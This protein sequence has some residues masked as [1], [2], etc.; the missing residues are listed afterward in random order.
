MNYSKNPKSLYNF[1]KNTVKTFTKKYSFQVETPCSPTVFLVRHLNIYGVITIEKSST[2]PF[3]IFAL[4]FLFDK[5][6]CFEHLYSYTFQKRFNFPKPLA[7]LSAKSCSFYLPKL[8]R[9][10]NCIPVFRSDVK[11][12][13]TLKQGVN[14]LL[15]GENL[16]IFPDINYSN[17][18]N[19]SNGIYKGFLYLEKLYFSKTNRHLNFVTLKID[20]KNKKIIQTNEISFC[21]NVDF[22]SQVSVISQKIVDGIF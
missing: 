16:L 15:N 18:L 13:E 2:V 1:T 7:F 10:A 22:K 12:F 8:C 5:D 6:T 21:D 4:N 17:E 19:G 9:S 3:R 14:A 11:S 20:E